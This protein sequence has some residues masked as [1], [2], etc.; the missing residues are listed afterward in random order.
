MEESYLDVAITADV[1]SSVLTVPKTKI[2]A[3][4]DFTDKERLIEF[5]IITDKLV[6]K[7]VSKQH[8]FNFLSYLIIWSHS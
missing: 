8:V 4:K 3:K 1:N 6:G 2:T 5:G 7:S